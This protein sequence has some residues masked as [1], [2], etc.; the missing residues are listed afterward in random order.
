MPPREPDEPRGERGETEPPDPPERAPDPA[1]ADW[2]TST[3]SRA[4]HS[5]WSPPAPE[6]TSEGSGPNAAEGTSSEQ[7]PSLRGRHLA[8]ASLETPPDRAATTPLPTD[9]PEPPPPA[10]TR[11]I[12]PPSPPEAHPA[13]PTSPRTEQ[14]AR[15][16]QSPVTRPSTPT[17]P[18]PTHWSALGD[19][20]GAPSALGRL[21]AIVV[22]CGLGWALAVAV[23]I[24]L[25]VFL[26]SR[27]G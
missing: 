27:S 8:W 23:G 18:P 7:P 4:D 16:A 19:E 22:T 5:V 14:P 12:G 2:R 15:P 25:L 1:P 10:D 6:G 9:H 26:V 13:P 11:P 24:W 20:S 17:E 21:L 3:Y